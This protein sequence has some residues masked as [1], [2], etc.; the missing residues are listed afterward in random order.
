M[1][2]T[3][4][5]R[6]RESSSAGEYVVLLEEYGFGWGMH[7]LGMG[8]RGSAEVRSPSSSAVLLLTLAGAEP[9]AFDCCWAVGSGMWKTWG[10]EWA[11]PAG[12]RKKIVWPAGV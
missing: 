8:F 1:A 4:F 11:C 2:F 9:Q 6:G 7:G 5:E 12:G 3:L 10:R